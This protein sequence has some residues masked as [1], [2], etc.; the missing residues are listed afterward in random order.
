MTVLALLPLASAAVPVT[1]DAAFFEQKVLPIL[2]TRCL[3]CHGSG[4]ELRA[5]L[6]LTRR[7]GLLAGGDSGPAVDLADPLA[8]LLLRKIS[9]QDEYNQM[10]PTGPLPEAERAVL[11]QWVQ[12][13]IPWSEAVDIEESAREG[14]R[15]ITKGDGLEGWAYFS[16]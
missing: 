3:E 9:Y 12:R 11:R 13:G 4:E 15:R 16:V 7:E 2:E 5:G 10:P 1:D 14:P 8:S 6:W